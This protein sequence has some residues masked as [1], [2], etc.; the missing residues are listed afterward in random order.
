MQGMVEPWM[1]LV[2]RLAKTGALVLFLFAWYVASP[3]FV[4]HWCNAVAPWAMSAL[5][6]AY[7][8]AE[9]YFQN[10]QLPG[11]RV[12]NEYIGWCGSAIENPA[13]NSPASDVNMSARTNYGIT[14]I[15]RR[16]VA[17][18]LV[19]H[20]HPIALTPEVDG[21]LRVTLSGFASLETRLTEIEEQTGFGWGWVNGRITIGPPATIQRMAADHDAKA[22]ANRR[23]GRIAMLISAAAPLMLVAGIAWQFQRRVRM[24]STDR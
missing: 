8:P 2:V 21:D 5:Q 6:V 7:W 24:S 15:P 1:R 16:I 11:G 22:K 12:Y 9:Q 18:N 20:T 23:R 10:P 13:A 3:V 19:G 4:G 14:D 17:D